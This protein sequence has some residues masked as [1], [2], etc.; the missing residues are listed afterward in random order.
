MIQT[1]AQQWLWQWNEP[2]AAN[3]CFLYP[4]KFVIDFL[5]VKEKNRSQWYFLPVISMLKILVMHTFGYHFF[6]LGLYGNRFG[7]CRIPKT[8]SYFFV[9]CGR[10]DPKRRSMIMKSCFYMG[11]PETFRKGPE[12]VSG[13]LW[14][15]LRQTDQTETR[16]SFCVVSFKY[17]FL[18]FIFN[19]HLG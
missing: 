12:K 9:C 1:S 6:I 16:F 14:L 8:A 7:W 19:T 18:N 13:T 3:Q 5:T 11:L 17:S 2:E 10:V 15:L 4:I